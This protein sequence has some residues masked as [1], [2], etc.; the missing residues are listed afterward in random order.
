MSLRPAG[1]AR[2]RSTLR[3]PAAKANGS[4]SCTDARYIPDVDE[5]GT[6]RGF[7]VLATDIT[8]LRD[9]YAQVRAWLSGSR[10]FERMKRR[11]IARSLHEG[12][13]QDL[14]AAKLTL[15]HLKGSRTRWRARGWPILAMHRFV[16][17]IG[18][19]ARR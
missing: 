5:S 7:Y 12:I 1:A 17:A 8:E 15:E 9:S 10:S 13:A 11:S 18:A 19:R 16:H 14:F 3:A 2:S 6:V 4:P